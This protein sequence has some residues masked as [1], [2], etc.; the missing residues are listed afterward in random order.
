MACKSSRL[1]GILWIL[2]PDKSMA[3]NFFNMQTSI[4][5]T[6]KL[7]LHNVKD[8]RFFSLE[9]KPSGIALMWLPA[10]L[11][12]S[13][14]VRLPKNS[15]IFPKIDG[16]EKEEY[17]FVHIANQFIHIQMPLVSSEEKQREKGR[18]KKGIKL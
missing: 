11:R 16:N 3:S 12:V 10:K 14:F 7:L 18:K 17:I 1:S 2:F 13:N 4:G 6:C 15:G 9:N 5:N 8:V